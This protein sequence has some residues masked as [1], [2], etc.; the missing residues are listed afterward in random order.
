MTAIK[1]ID[2]LAKAKAA[3]GDNLPE[4]I[5]ELAREANRSSGIAASAKI[6]CS[7]TA[8]SQVLSNKYPASLDRIEGRVRGALMGATVTCPVLGEI[9]RDYCL[10]QQ[11][12]DNTM[13]SSVRGRIYRACRGIGVPQCSHSHHKPR[14][15]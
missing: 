1:R 8:L 7:Q 3:W 14:G 10:E 15:A 5:A 4:W 2:F 12:M 9:G 13:A 6:G 11:E